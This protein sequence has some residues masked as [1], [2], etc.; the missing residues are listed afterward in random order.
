MANRLPEKLTSMR[1]QLGYSQGDVA[2]KMNI[3]VAEFMHWENGTSIPS[4][5]S[6]K[7]LADIF[8]IKVEMLVD[9]T[10]EVKL[11][12][13]STESVEIP[14][15]QPSAEETKTI[16]LGGAG[17][18]DATKP[19]STINTMEFQP[20]VSSEIIDGEPMEGTQTR[21]IIR[22]AR[23][24]KKQKR[25]TAL[26]IAG[27][28]AAALLLVAGLIMI[29][30]GAGGSSV[31][32]G[33]IN[34]LALGDTY[35][36][37]IK[38]SGEL[39]TY[40]Q[41]ADKD[42]FTGAVQVS[43]YDSHAVG[44]NSEG[45]VFTNGDDSVISDWKNVTQIAAGRTHTVAL[46]DDGDVLCTGSDAGCEVSGWANISSL[47][48]GNA[49]TLGISSDGTLHA[50]GA[51][52]VDGISGVKS[53]A[54]GDSQILLISTSGTVKSYSLTDAAA[55]DVTSWSDIDAAA[56]GSNFAA[57]MTSKGKVVIVTDDEEMKKK[58]E[59]WTDIRYI[60]A[61]GSTLIAVDR[62]G[63][64]HGA[65]DNSHGQYVDN[66]S[67]DKKEEEVKKLDMVKEITF[68]ESTAN[69]QVKWKAVTN[70]DY[71]EVTFEP[72]LSSEIPQTS[73][74]SIS[75]PASELS[76]GSV[77]QVTV[78]ACS[79]NTDKYEKSD[80]AVVSYTFE[81]KTVTL[82]TPSN[83]YTESTADNWIVRWDPVEN[84][85]YYMVSLD[86]REEIR[87]DQNAFF[88]EHTG[89]IDQSLHTVKI[90]AHSD[91]SSYSESVPAQ[92][93]VTYQ[94]PS[95]SVTLNFN[96]D[97]GTAVE[98]KVIVV[99]AGSHALSE[100]VTPDLYPSGEF[101]LANPDRTV[102]VRSDYSVDVS[103][104]RIGGESGGEGGGE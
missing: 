25:K 9:N 2:A 68:T 99:K 36:M 37:Y 96:T 64:M 27:V 20:T 34:R 30:R 19:V 81:S 39:Q 95:F 48:A 63:T 86:D 73:S 49:V 57:G 90:T 41:F 56:V 100:I 43:A 78:V 28:A 65:G 70:A 101:T 4:I 5:H 32:L 76:D 79:N 74:T 98:H 33:S 16:D 1:K 61:N 10:V 18:M 103:L 35:S 102:D 11:P 62:S 6:L 17:Q 13:I 15:V 40:G 67:D 50:S 71:Y 24:T 26:I 31:A 14:F 89:F 85:T 47:Y 80:P 8:G 104:A 66:T 84:A 59:S 94:L 69:I 87:S 75:I 91:S 54:V 72:A 53:A 77:Y 12:Q 83:I 42:L 58:V 23:P 88:Y 82:D 93:E 55:F 44:L 29:L 92:V 46:T 21:P 52:A 60:A 7:K 38:K 3:P 45:K 97:D 22:P 51:P